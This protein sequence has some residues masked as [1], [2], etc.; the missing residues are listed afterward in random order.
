MDEMIVE[1][2]QEMDIVFVD[3][4]HAV[5]IVVQLRVVNVLNVWIVYDIHHHDELILQKLDY[6]HCR[7]VDDEPKNCINVSLVVE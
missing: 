6:N 4:L 2:I 7:V 3:H 5:I 1:D